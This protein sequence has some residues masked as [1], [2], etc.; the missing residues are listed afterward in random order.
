MLKK[1]KDF[2][3]SHVESQSSILQNKA[4]YRGY[5]CVATQIT[6][7]ISGKLKGSLNLWLKNENNYR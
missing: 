7:M 3:T 6:L 4:L 1:L 2:L 5:R